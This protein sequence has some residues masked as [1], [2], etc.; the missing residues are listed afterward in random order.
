MSKKLLLIVTV[1]LALSF[2][3]SGAWANGVLTC[4]DHTLVNEFIGTAD[5]GWKDVVGTDVPFN[6]FSAAFDP[7]T[8]ILSIYTNW[9]PGDHVF[10]PV[11]GFPFITADLFLNYDPNTK[12]ALAAVELFGAANA[13]TSNNVYY[14]PTTITT[15]F[16]L[17]GNEAFGYGKF[18]T[19]N[20]N[21]AG[22]PSFLVPVTASGGTTDTVDVLWSAQSATEPLF[23]FS[24]DLDDIVGLDPNN[25][26]F[27][28]AS[29][30]CANDV[31][32]CRPIPLP[33]SLLL[34][35]SGL[36]GLGVMG[37]RRKR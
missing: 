8:H 13:T 26:S 27:L 9:G 19:T 37:F 16:D 4:S 15:S 1:L 30:T 32:T 21:V 10:S 18:Y 17:F 29:A 2:G 35:G 12:T 3:V 31:I 7:T 6:T 25:F 36:L 20:D 5:K 14:N 28:W 11:P 24:V 22:P 23:Y 33:P 34:L